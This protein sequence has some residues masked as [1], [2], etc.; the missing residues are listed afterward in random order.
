MRKQVFVVEVLTKE[1]DGCGNPVPAKTEGDIRKALMKGLD[2]YD[3]VTVRADE[4]EL[5]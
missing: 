2:V 1:R 4:E 5:A 3:S